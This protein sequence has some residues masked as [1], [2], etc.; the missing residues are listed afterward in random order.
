MKRV[1]IF[2]AL[3]A[4]TA[5]GV[6]ADPLEGT[7]QTEPDEG[8]YAHVMIEPCGDNF[9]GKIART[10]KDGAEYQ[11]PNLGKALVID[12]APEGDGNYRGQVWRPSND[13]IYLGKIALNGD[14]MKLSGC[15]AG[16]LICSKQTWA[17]IQ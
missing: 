17:R 12:M 4:V 5:G 14:R 13:R 10:F 16:G 8:A 11:S 9:C 2:A 15:V 1:T 7:W 6:A 3:V